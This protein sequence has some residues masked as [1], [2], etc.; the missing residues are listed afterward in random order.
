MIL[1]GD[2]CVCVEGGGGT[3]PGPH[4]TECYC[5]VWVCLGCR[6]VSCGRLLPEGRGRG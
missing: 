3:Y 6:E 2:V 1:V 4:E 5:W